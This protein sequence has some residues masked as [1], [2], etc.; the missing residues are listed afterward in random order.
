M[1]PFWRRLRLWFTDKAA[2]IDEVARLQYRVSQLTLDVGLVTEQLRDLEEY[3]ASLEAE[4]DPPPD[5]DGRSGAGPDDP[6]SPPVPL[7]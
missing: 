6:P 1:I 7:R 3:T 5:P 2:L 4:L